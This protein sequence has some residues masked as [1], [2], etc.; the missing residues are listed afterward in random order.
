MVFNLRR[1]HEPAEVEPEVTPEVDPTA[2]SADGEASGTE[3][4]NALEHFKKM[5]HLDPNLP[6]P[7]LN[8]VETAL[9]AGDAEK[10]VE[11]EQALVEDDSPYPEVSP[12]SALA[13]ATLESGSL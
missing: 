3:A 4:L 7:E 10:G 8:D 13:G 2:G 11:I 5:H 9:Q 1:R 6:I 12:P